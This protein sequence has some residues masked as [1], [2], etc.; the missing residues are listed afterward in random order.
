[1]SQTLSK[2]DSIKIKVFGY[3]EKSLKTL[4]Q[5]LA[6]DTSRKIIMLLINKDMYLNEVSKKLEIQMNTTS[7]HLKKLVDLGL[8]IVTKKKITRKGINHDHYKMTPNVFVKLNNTKKDMVNSGILKRIFKEGVKFV[9]VFLVAVTGIS[10]FGKDNI[11]NPQEI[12][13]GNDVIIPDIDIV[14]IPIEDVTA[15]QYEWIIIISIV[16][17]ISSVIFIFLKK[18]KKG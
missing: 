13:N 15:F 4:G 10:I 3:D 11:P 6:N 7:F 1:M 8:V 12:I 17:I 18:R 2:D 9:V 14:K 5:L 16:V